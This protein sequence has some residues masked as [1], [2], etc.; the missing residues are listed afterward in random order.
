MDLSGSGFGEGRLGDDF[1]LSLGRPIFG[2][3]VFLALVLPLADELVALGPFLLVEAVFSLPIVFL[4]EVSLGRLI[5]ISI[6]AFAFVFL[7]AFILFLLG[8]V[9]PLGKLL[10]VLLFVPEF[11]VEVVLLR[12]VV[13]V[14]I[15][16]A[17]PFE[18]ITSLVSFRP[19]VPEVV[20]PRGVA[21]GRIGVLRF[22]YFHVSLF[23][24]DWRLPRLPR[25]PLLENWFGWLGR[26]I[27]L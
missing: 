7:L 8:P 5:V 2:L 25:L 17:V 18:L 12:L 23:P 24:A 4:L 22:L 1:C 19:F 27:E 16:V 15:W 26:D 3:G 21:L 9:L 11:T 10:F 13:P 6:V 20:L 14:S